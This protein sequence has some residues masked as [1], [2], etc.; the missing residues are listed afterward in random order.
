M[1]H[2]IEKVRITLTKLLLDAEVFIVSNRL[3]Q[4]QIGGEATPH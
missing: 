2:A 4:P 3:A 1:C